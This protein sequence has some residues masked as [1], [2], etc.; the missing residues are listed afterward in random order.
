MCKAVCDVQAHHTAS[1]FYIHRALIAA[2][3]LKR[4]YISTR[5]HVVTY[6][7]TKLPVHRANPM[8]RVSFW[9]PLLLLFLVLKQSHEDYKQLS[10]IGDQK[11]DLETYIKR[12]REL[13]RKNETFYSECKV[14]IYINIYIINKYI[15]MHNPFNFER[16]TLIITEQK[17]GNELMHRKNYGNGYCIF[18]V[19]TFIQLYVA[20]CY[21]SGY[22]IVHVTSL[23]FRCVAKCY[24]T[25]YYNLYVSLI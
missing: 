13:V 9:V 25:G 5:L 8:V 21:V 1:A 17:H 19:D 12:I 4:Y 22:Y 10:D 18:Y 2:H 14:S 23:L 7:K 16:H 11:F 20:Q 24:V 3:N 15:C 6:S